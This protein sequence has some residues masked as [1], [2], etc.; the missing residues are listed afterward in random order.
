M[1]GSFRARS[2]IQAIVLLA[3]SLGASR[4]AMV[5][6]RGLPLRGQI[7]EMHK[8]ADGV[9]RIRHG[10]TELTASPLRKDGGV[11]QKDIED[12]KYLSTVLRSIQSA[13][14]AR[15]EQNL[16]DARTVRERRVIHD[17]L[18]KRRVAAG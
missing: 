16:L 12:N 8:R 4:R 14:I 18:A 13:Q 17:S 9:V 7:V 6:R 15:D 3:W 11:T 2:S 10:R 5:A 1:R